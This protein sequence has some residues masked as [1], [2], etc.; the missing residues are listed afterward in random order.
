[1]H[2]CLF[3]VARGTER[4][5][6]G[7]RAPGA[8]LSTSAVPSQVA[9]LLFALALPFPALKEE[10]KRHWLEKEAGE[11]MSKKRG[12]ESDGQS[13]NVWGEL[14]E[15]VIVG[16]RVQC[17]HRAFHQPCFLMGVWEAAFPVW[18]ALVCCSNFLGGGIEVVAGD[19]SNLL[20]LPQHFY[21]YFKCCSFVYCCAGIFFSPPTHYVQYCHVTWRASRYLWKGDASAP[22]ATPTWITPGSECQRWK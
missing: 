13:K 1:M 14:G 12:T 15:R 4:W 19:W 2:A 11:Q 21:W 7:E 17:T 6:K 9:P 20:L 22:L 5:A 18:I 3:M 16:R 10:E 8:S